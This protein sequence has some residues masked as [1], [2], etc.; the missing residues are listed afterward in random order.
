MLKKKKILHLILAKLAI[1]HNPKLQCDNSTK[2]QCHHRCWQGYCPG[3]SSPWHCSDIINSRAVCLYHVFCY[4]TSAGDVALVSIWHSSGSKFIG[5]CT[6]WNKHG[7]VK[8]NSGVDAQTFPI[9][10]SVSTLRCNEPNKP[11]H[12]HSCRLACRQHEKPAVQWFWHLVYTC[13]SEVIFFWRLYSST[14]PIHGRQH[15]S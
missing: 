5:R 15:V 14:R 11:E 6:S 8:S 7:E 9:A 4:V 13:C 1:T 12:W 2:H 10:T 3:S